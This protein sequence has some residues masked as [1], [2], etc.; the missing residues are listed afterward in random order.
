MGAHDKQMLL[1]AYVKHT[2]FSI[3]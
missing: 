3:T 2:L 1:R